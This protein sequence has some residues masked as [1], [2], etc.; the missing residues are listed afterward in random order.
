MRA[1]LAGLVLVLGAHAPVAGPRARPR[2][3][4][5]TKAPL[6]ARPAPADTAAEAVSVE[7]TDAEPRQSS[8][9]CCRVFSQRWSY[10]WMNPAACTSAGG[11]CVSPD[12]C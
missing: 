1:L 8:I 10:S 2:S 12:H 5:R 7:P 11:S 9:C 4:A 6:D 3:P